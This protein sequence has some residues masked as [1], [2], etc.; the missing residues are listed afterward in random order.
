MGQ[1]ANRNGATYM[2]KTHKQKRVKYT[3]RVWVG[4]TAAE[5]ALLIDAASRASL[6]LSAFARVAVRREIGVA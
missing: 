2:T 1:I 4:L 3:S 5:Y 6:S